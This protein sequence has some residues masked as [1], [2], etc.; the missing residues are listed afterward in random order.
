MRKEIVSQDNKLP[1]SQLIT[2]EDAYAMIKGD[3]PPDQRDPRP[4]PTPPWMLSGK[5]NEYEIEADALKANL[6]GLEST[7]EQ[8]DGQTADRAALI[9]QELVTYLMDYMLTLQVAEERRY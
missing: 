8:Y 6:A 1:Y 2:L 7:L 5:M 3:A 4:P 9:K